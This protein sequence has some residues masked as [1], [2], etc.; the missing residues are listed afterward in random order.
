MRSWPRRRRPARPRRCPARGRSVEGYVETEGSLPVS[1]QCPLAPIQG[2]RIAVVCPGPVGRRY[3]E[4]CRHLG[5]APPGCP[6]SWL[7]SVDPTGYEDGRAMPVPMTRSSALDRS[8]GR[9]R[10]TP[11][12]SYEDVVSGEKWEDCRDLYTGGCRI[13]LSISPFGR[14]LALA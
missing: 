5:A 9:S 4:W 8:R 12:A 3:A 7:G 13:D 14:W 6:G 11:G 1:G 2:W 10:L